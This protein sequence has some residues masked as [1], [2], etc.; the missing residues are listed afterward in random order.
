MIV[1]SLYICSLLFAFRSFSCYIY[2][3]VPKIIY[4]MHNRISTMEYQNILFNSSHKGT[5]LTKKAEKLL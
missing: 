4:V 3:M 5:K 1:G 2:L